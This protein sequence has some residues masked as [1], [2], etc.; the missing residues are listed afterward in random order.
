[1]DIYGFRNRIGA[2]GLLCIYLYKMMDNYGHFYTLCSVL[3]KRIF[4][5]MNLPFYSKATYLII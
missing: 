3:C 4:C 2:Y 5:G 1:M